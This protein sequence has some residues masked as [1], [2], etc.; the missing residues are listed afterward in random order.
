MLMPQSARTGAAVRLHAKQIKTVTDSG[1]NPKLV[2][3]FTVSVR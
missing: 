2:I 1:T 3:I